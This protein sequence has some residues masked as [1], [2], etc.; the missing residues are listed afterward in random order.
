M[1]K[2]TPLKDRAERWLD[3]HRGALESSNAFVRAYGLPLKDLRQF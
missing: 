1:E 3:E 2:R